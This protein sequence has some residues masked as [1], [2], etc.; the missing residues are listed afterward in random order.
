MAAALAGQRIAQVRRVGKHIV[1]D[2]ERAAA[3]AKLRRPT[4]SG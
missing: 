1:M 3:H 2:L 4:R